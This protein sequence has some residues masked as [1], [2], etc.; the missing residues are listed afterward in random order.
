MQG[1]FVKTTANQQDTL[2]ARLHKPREG[3]PVWGRGRPRD[4]PAPS[5]ALME[6]WSQWPATARMAR[7]RAW[8]VQQMGTPA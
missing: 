1:D 2:Y 4:E 3:L 6:A 8:R 7:Y 5:L